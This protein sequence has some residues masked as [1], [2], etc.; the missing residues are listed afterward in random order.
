MPSPFNRLRSKLTRAI[1]AHLIESGCGT[2][3]DTFPDNSQR[4]KPSL[5]TTVR[6]T[7][8]SPEVPMSGIRSIPVHIT[9]RGSAVRDPEHPDDISSARVAF[10][11]RLALVADALMQSADGQ[12]WHAT[13]DLITASGRALAV[14]DPGSNGDMCDFSCQAWYDGGEGDAEPDQEGTAWQEILIF[15]AICSPSNVD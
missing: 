1:V 10:D 12:S 14:D 11:T 15:R 6:A 2:A 8:A 5:C 4:D 13:A 9:I 7:I 3:A